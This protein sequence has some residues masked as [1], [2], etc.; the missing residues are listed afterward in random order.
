MLTD[1]AGVPLGVEVSGA[2]THDMRL[3]RDTLKS[4]PVKRPKPSRHKK[5]HFCADKGY[6]YPD[7]RTLIARWGYTARIK[8]RGEEKADRES[9]PG[10]RAR[11]WVVERTHSW[12]NRFRR[13]LIRWEKKADNYLA[14]LHLAFA[15][16]TLRAADV[17]G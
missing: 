7:V 16:I 5:Q 11:R 15:H 12:L 2:N 1:G 4:V 17:L 6:D 8:S 14:L 10:Y 9:I 3:V 13:L